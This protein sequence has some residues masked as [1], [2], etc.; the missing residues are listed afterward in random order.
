MPESAQKRSGVCFYLPAGNGAPV[1]ILSAA[2]DLPASWRSAAMLTEGRPFG[3]NTC[4]PA[5]QLLSDSPQTPEKYTACRWVQHV[6]QQ[7]CDT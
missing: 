3:V 4:I 6:G 7:L 5:R 2:P 1:S